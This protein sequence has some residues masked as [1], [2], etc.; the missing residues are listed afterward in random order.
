MD[1]HNKNVKR[2]LTN[3]L[4]VIVLNSL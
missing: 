2:V 1:L 4:A 3:I